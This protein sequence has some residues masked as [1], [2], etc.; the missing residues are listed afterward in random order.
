[1]TKDT[2]NAMGLSIWRSLSHRPEQVTRYE[3]DDRGLLVKEINPANKVTVYTY[4]ANGNL[5]SR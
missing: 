1:M 5:V 2:V 4:D 3:Y